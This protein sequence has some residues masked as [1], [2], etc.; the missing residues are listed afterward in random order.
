MLFD[1]HAHVNF[2][3]FKD[4]ADEVIKKSL[5]NETWM[6]NVGSQYSTSQRAVEYADAYAG[7][8]PHTKNG[9]QVVLN[10]TKSSGFGVGVYASVG[11]HPIHIKDE[12]FDYDKYLE[13]AKSEKV[14]A[15][16]EMGLDYHHF[17]PPRL[18]ETASRR[19]AGVGDSVKELKAKQKEVFEKAI[20]LANQVNKPLIVHCWDAYDDLLEILSNKEVIKKGVIHSFIGS[21]KTARKFVNLGFKIGLNG[22]ITY[23]E[24]YDKL[25]RELSLE[26]IV[27]ETDCP[28]LTPQPLS[29]EERNEPINTK[30]V[31]E[32]I[33]RV[34]EMEIPEVIKV[35]T[36]NARKVFTPLNPRTH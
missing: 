23:S 16:G 8:H 7:V 34:R 29:R 17:D 13:L 31:A 28:Y 19:E 27:L 26:D 9:S 20:D 14:V 10:D 24:S 35:T 3:A 21:H 1:T 15:I 25:I 18:A 32:K 2:N 4:D 30:Y 33:S 11:L 5:E 6:I 36:Q 22:I 12:D